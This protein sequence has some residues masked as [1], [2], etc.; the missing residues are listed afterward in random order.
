[1]Q[2]SLKPEA[3]DEIKQSEEA[4]FREQEQKYNQKLEELRNSM[5]NRFK[6]LFDVIDVQKLS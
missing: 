2:L 5:E 3:Y 1:M 4:R 6:T